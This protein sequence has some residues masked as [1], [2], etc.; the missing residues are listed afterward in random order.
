MERRPRNKIAD[1]KR[2]IAAVKLPAVNREGGCGARG[3]IEALAAIVETVT[4]AEM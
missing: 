3:G 2:S 1:A 4:F